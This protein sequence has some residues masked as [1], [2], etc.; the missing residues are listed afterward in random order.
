MARPV[1]ATVYTDLAGC[2]FRLVNFDSRQGVADWDNKENYFREHGTFPVTHYT[3]QVAQQTAVQ[4]AQ[5]L[6][7]Y[8]IKLAVFKASRRPQCLPNENPFDTHSRFHTYY[9]RNSPPP[10]P[11][12]AYCVRTYSLGHFTGHLHTTDDTSESSSDSRP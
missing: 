3:T 7:S 4:G 10:P 5:S 6:R 9:H 2:H 12:T 8:L 11:T 1:T